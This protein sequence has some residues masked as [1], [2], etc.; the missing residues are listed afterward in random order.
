MS[1]PSLWAGLG[2]SVFLAEVGEE[3]RAPLRLALTLIGGAIVAMIAGVCVWCLVMIPY[4]LASGLGGEG[5]KGLG[6]AALAVVTPRTWDLQTSVVFL[7]LTT[8]VDAAPMVAFVAFAAAMARRPLHA[9]AT[10]AP[11]VRWRLLLAGMVL[12]SLVLA[13]MV[14]AERTLGGDG[15]PPILTISPSLW[16]RLVYGL[17][18]LML[19]PAAMAEELIFRGW[20][21]RQSGAFAERTG[22]LLLVSSVLFA[23]AHFAVDPGGADPDAFLQLALMGAGFGYMTLRLGGIE[24]AAGAHAANNLLIVLFIHPLRPELPTNSGGPLSLVTDLALLSGYFIIT[25]AIVRWPWLRALAGVR[26]GEISPPDDLQA[27]PA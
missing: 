13:P 19:I 11:H 3:E 1:V 7:V 24:F 22:A 27:D 5:L 25:E 18:A 14:V 21:L 10:A 23:G 6:E 12:A 2:K 4:T 8:A 16:G 26:S 15:P 9:Y 20:L 17:A